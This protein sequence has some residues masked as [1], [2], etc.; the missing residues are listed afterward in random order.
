MKFCVLRL[1]KNLISCMKLF[2]RTVHV[3]KLDLFKEVFL[4]FRLR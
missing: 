3:R 1:M 4:V 2:S